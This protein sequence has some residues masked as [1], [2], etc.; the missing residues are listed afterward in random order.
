LKTNEKE[1]QMN[2]LRRVFILIIG[3]VCLLTFN[4]TA[5]SS[6][7]LPTPEPTPHPTTNPKV[8]LMSPTF[9]EMINGQTQTIT[10][11]IKNVGNTFANNVFTTATIESDKAPFTVEFL[12]KSNYIAAMSWSNTKDMKMKIVVDDDAPSGSYAVKLTHSFLS[13]EDEIKTEED[14]FY[15]KINNVAASL[16]P[17]VIMTNFTSS[18]DSIAPGDTFSLS[19]RVENSGT[20]RANDVQVLLDGLKT[21]EVYMA[22]STNSAVFTALEGGSGDIIT[23]SLA[24]SS[25][26][27]TGSYP[28]VFKVKYKDQDNEEYEKEY[29]YYVNVGGTASSANQGLVQVTKLT[30]PT[31][32]FG[33]GSPFEVNMAIQNIGSKKASNIKISMEDNTEGAIVPR[34]AS[35]QTFSSMEPGE[36]KELKFSFAAT[37]KSIT[38]NYAIGFKVEYESGDTDDDGKNIVTSYV[39]YV[40]VNASNP[41]GDKAADG[42]EEKTSVPKIIVSEY[43][44]DPIMVRAGQEFDLSMTFQNTHS[45]KP[46]ENIRAYLTVVETSTEKKGSVFTPVNCSNTFYIDSI[47]PKGTSYQQ[48]RMYTIPD[49]DPITY[50]LEVNFEYQDQDYNKYEAKELIGINVK[51][52]TKLE[53][54]EIVMPTDGTIG[55]A[56]NISFDLYNT[57]K[58][59]LYNLMI[60]VEGEGFDTA[61]STVYYGKFTVYNSNYYD[62]AFSP[63][64]AG[65]QSGALII[66]YEDAAGEK[67]EERH[68]FTMNVAE[69]MGMDEGM[70]HEDMMMEQPQENIFMRL[71][72]NPFV[73]GGVVLMIVVI[74]IGAKIVRKKKQKGIDLDE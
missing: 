8:K 46:I 65:E 18:S 66:S 68:E 34:T 10:I 54:S 15:V 24:V 1:K 63:T 73:W 55:M 28:L 7:V 56:S 29:Y 5:F 36:T 53:T 32:T 64:T 45:S 12:D 31:D 61:A 51:Q 69:D 52:Y 58:A 3:M 49:A 71:V 60:R 2:K 9:V 35:V 72:K 25:K 62:G 4:A 44:S 43:A 57:G 38:Q 37:S 16:K 21:D 6:E 59:D 11:T 26:V 20:K 41:E 27:K 40:G 30:S 67:I 17:N 23:Y 42:E 48:L 13:L 47:P 14:T 70:M 22:N 39:Q 33:V 50:T 19:A 74:I